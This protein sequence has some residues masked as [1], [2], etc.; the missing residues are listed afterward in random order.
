MIN[1]ICTGE[2]TAQ[3]VEIISKHIKLFKLSQKTIAQYANITQQAFSQGLNKHYS[4]NKYICLILE[5]IANNCDSSIYDNALKLYNSLD[6]EIETIQRKDKELIMKP[7]ECNL[8]YKIDPSADKRVI[9]D[10]DDSQLLRL[11]EFL[12]AL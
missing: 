3:K 10:C 11:L 12:Q 7:K 9:I 4:N 1:L 2:V 6:L 8:Y 5:Y